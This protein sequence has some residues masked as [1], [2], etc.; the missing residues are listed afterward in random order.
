MP[1]FICSFVH[2]N[3]KDIGKPEEELELDHLYLLLSQHGPQ[4]LKFETQG[5]MSLKRR[6]ADLLL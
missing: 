6:N 3:Q 1:H 5:V 4:E 2:N